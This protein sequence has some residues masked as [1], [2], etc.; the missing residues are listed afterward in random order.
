MATA[1]IE[2]NVNYFNINCDLGISEEVGTKAWFSAIKKSGYKYAYRWM[3]SD[4]GWMWFAKT[5][6]SA[7]LGAVMSV[8]ENR[9]YDIKTARKYYTDY[10]TV[11]TVDDIINEWTLED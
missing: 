10:V 8:V 2:N 6:A 11:Y 5:N 4:D 3:N 9:K 7:T 1:K